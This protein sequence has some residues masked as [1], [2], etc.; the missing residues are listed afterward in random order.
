[1]Y[2]EKD[3]ILRLINEIIRALI[4]WILGKDMN[5]EEEVI[6]SSEIAELYKELLVMSDEGEITSAEDRLLEYLDLN[7]LQYLQM[8]LMFYQHLNEKTEAYLTEHN[9]SKTE[10]LDGVTDMANVYGY[11]SIIETFVD[12]FDR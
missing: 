2:E 1:M 12:S 10:V 5:R 6:L 9:F 8:A 7:N 11:G 4:K 3:Y